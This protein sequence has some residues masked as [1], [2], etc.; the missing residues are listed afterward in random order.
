MCVCVFVQ[1]ASP[2][3]DYI[4][5]KK[6]YFQ[7]EVLMLIFKKKTLNINNAF[8][9][10]VNNALWETENTRFTKKIASANSLCRFHYPNQLLSI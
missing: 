1:E 3:S 9:R 8:Y 4:Y 5:V 2:W 10:S 6:M 7:L